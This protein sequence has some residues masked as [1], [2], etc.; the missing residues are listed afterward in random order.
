MRKT[1]IAAVAGIS[2]AMCGLMPATSAEVEWTMGSLVGA[3]DD[4][5]RMLEEYAKRVA[6]RT[7]GRVAIKVVPV[8]NLGFQ[9]AD[10]LR[11]M[12]QRAMQSM[13]IYPYMMARDE[14]RLTAFIP[15]GALLNQEDNLKVADLQFELS[16]GIY[17]DWDLVVVTRTGFALDPDTLLYVVSKEPMR[18]FDDLRKI[19]LRHGEPIGLEAWNN[20]GV[21]ASA[22]PFAEL[23]VSLRTGVLDATVLSA[24]YVKSTSI[25]E[26]TGYLTPVMNITIAAPNVITVHTEDWAAVPDDLKAVMQEVGEELYEE[27]LAAWR[28]HKGETEAV[29]FLVEAGMEELPPFP[30]EE[31]RQIANALVEVWLNRCKELGEDVLAQCNQIA[32]LV[33]N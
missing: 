15:H 16:R 24:Q 31:R 21:S 26:V 12:Q 22:P 29:K 13:H 8:S 32:A 33:E 4:G 25:Y 23:Y 17:D 28:E 9:R 7:D 30:E 19:K 27:S 1:L 3:N 6:E 20:I 14:S 10:G 2:V 18:T 11:I 5:T